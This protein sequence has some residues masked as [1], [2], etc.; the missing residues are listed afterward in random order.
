[1]EIIFVLVPLSLLIA[2]CGLAAYGWALRRGQF[3][4]LDSPPLRLLAEESPPDPAPAEIAKKGL[5]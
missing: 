1:M 4:D 2:L 3:D 5:K